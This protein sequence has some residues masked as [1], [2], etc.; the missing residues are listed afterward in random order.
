MQQ[1]LAIHQH[2]DRVLSDVVGTRI[3]FPI[4][5]EAGQRISTAGLQDGAE[6]IFYHESSHPIAQIPLIALC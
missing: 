4:A 1:E 5:I 3:A 2:T 6:N